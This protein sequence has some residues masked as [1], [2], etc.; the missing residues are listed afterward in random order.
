[1]EVLRLTNPDY[2][3][4]IDN[5]LDVYL[6]NKPPDCILYSDDG[7]DIKIHK[8]LFGQTNFLREILSSVKEQC[9]RTFEIL[10][11]CTKKELG[12]L[13]SFL[14][15]GEMNFENVDEFI[16]IQENLVKVFGFSEDLILIDPNQES[17]VD[18]K[19]IDI[20]EELLKLDSCIEEATKIEEIAPDNLEEDDSNKTLIEKNLDPEYSGKSEMST[21][22]REIESITSSEISLE[23]VSD[24]SFV[25][26]TNISFTGKSDSGITIGR[27]DE[28]I[29]TIPV[30]ISRDPRM[31]LKRTKKFSQYKNKA[32]KSRYE[33]NSQ[34][35]ENEKSFRC[36]KCEQ[37]FSRK[38]T[39]TAHVDAVHMKL[40][41]SNKRILNKFQCI[42]CG[43]LVLQHET[44]EENLMSKSLECGFCSKRNL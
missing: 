38:G 43:K 17:V 29:S 23:D 6:K 33:E 36:V 13:V 8:E 20:E 40:K 21:S 1:M 16:R 25:D 5:H 44:L 22:D 31:H 7:G 27:S 11:P 10:C 12:Y 39:L 14:Y 28:N 42:K 19:N 32:K 26:N 30:R 2:I 3:E 15:D 41:K 4:T 35:Q 18:E 24:E 37:W 9:C 34:D